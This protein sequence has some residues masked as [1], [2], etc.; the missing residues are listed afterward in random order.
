MKPIKL[1]MS[2]FGSYAGVE[3]LDFAKLGESGLYL[4][5]GETGSGKTTIFDALSFALFGEASGSGRDKYPM[6]CSDFADEGAKTFVELDFASGNNKYRVRREIKRTGGQ[7]VHITLSDG[8]SLSGARDTKDKIAEIV[9]LD[10]DQFAQIVMIA[11]N[12]FLRFLQSGTDKRVEILRR[13]FNTATLKNF[14]ES[15]KSHAKKLDG[16]LL[17]VRRDFERYEIDPYKR[18]EKFVEWDAQI[19]ADDHAIAEY[20]KQIKEYEVKKTSV[21]QMIAVA[22]ALAKRFAEL[23]KTRAAFAS[24][25]AKSEE[26]GRLSEKRTRG[27]T[28]LRQVKPAADKAAE[29]NKRHIAAQASLAE[30]KKSAETARKESE[31]AK[32]ELAELQPIEKVQSGVDKIRREW[33]TESDKFKKLEALR[34]EYAEIDK[35]RQNLKTLHSEFERLNADF[36]RLDNE[37][38]LLNESFLRGQAGIIAAKLVDGTPCPVCGSAEHP[39][40]AKLTD[41]GVTEAGLK[42]AKAAVDRAQNG[43]GQK[44]DEC[45][46]LKSEI[47]TRE[48]RFIDDFSAIV[49]IV[50]KNTAGGLLTDAFTSAHRRVKE[51]TDNKQKAEKNLAELAAQRDKAAKR[52]GDAEKSHTSALTLVKEREKREI[53]HKDAN[54]R[55]RTDYVNSLN[56]NGFADE[57]EYAAVLV[58]EE[59][60][61]NMIKR[62]ADYEKDGERLRR[63][64][65]RLEEETAGKERPDME[66][67]NTEKGAIINAVNGLNKGR[68]EVRS[69]N[70][71]TKRMLEELRRSAETFVEL[72]KKHAAAKHLSD[73]ANGQ[74]SDAAAGRIDFETYAQAAYFDR[75]LGAANQRL[76]LMSQGRYKLLRKTESGDKRSKTGLDLEVSDAYTGK[77]RDA[78]SLSGGESFMASLS[79]ALGLSDIVQQTAG[80]VRLDAMFIDE[81]FGTLDAEVLELA[82]KTLSNMAESGRIIGIIS[83]VAE[84]RERIEKQ[85]RVEKT[86]RGSRISLAG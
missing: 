20:D 1:T 6:L 38:K 71:Q 13:I 4:I 16:E 68:E 36:N 14:Q 7:D 21:D 52:N 77:R 72:D 28:A 55:A 73:T 54:D 62:L 85:V 3:T 32:K 69:R 50:N 5:T 31:D 39:A 70:Q 46:R 65:N 41:G 24:H 47:D 76:G 83:H 48:N 82:V 10:R 43:R 19:K 53:E 75:V 8:T 40:P 26:M 18:D 57:T 59:T 79:L 58:T 80:G 25:Q 61:S 30:A 51:L 66:K 11:Q 29:T 35:K 12:D 9:G 63:D 37:Y 81:G 23:D 15:L 74:L 33:E 34:R 60:L 42:S 22:E 86:V 45:A 17:T 44:S 64:I 84:L 56:I 27:E 67:L 2:A 49:P 78:K